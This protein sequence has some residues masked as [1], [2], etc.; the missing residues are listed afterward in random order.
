MI[1]FCLIIQWLALFLYIWEWL[2]FAFCCFVVFKAKKR[3]HI[4][5]SFCCFS[6]SLFNALN[7]VILDRLILTVEKYLAILAGKREDV[8]VIL[9]KD[10]HFIHEGDASVTCIIHTVLNGN[11]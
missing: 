5:P 10:D 6:G 8:T 11:G 7:D 1:Y 2:C 9:D 3:A 4:A